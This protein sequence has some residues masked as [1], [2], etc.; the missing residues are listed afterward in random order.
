MHN[1]DSKTIQGVKITAVPAY[2]LVHKR[3]TGEF[4]HP[5]GEGNGYVLTF[6][7]TRIYIAGDT[8]NTPEMKALQDIDYAF[9]PMNLPYTMTPEMVAD[10]AKA[11]RPAVLYPYHYG[12]TD[13]NQLKELLKDEKDI[14][15][16]INGL[17]KADSEGYK[18]NVHEIEP[19]GGIVYE[20]KNVTVKA[21]PVKHGAWDFAFGF[22]FETRD[23]VV[24][25]SGDC[26]PGPALIEN[27]KGCDVLVHEVYSQAGFETRPQAWQR[28]HA[29][30]HTSSH[31]L[32]QIADRAGP[33]LLVLYHQ[34][35]WGASEQELLD[36][37][38]ERCDG[39]VVSGRDLDVL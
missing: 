34:L 38:Q 8:E 19:H 2:N 31:E 7:G 30:V 21:F 27:A 6:G 12:D 29:R 25:V 20:D 23:R 11:F 5:K 33:G 22:R 1:G 14:D 28:Y 32:A 16:R 35:F 17:E 3:D 39:P 9:L 26:V 18:V 13:T 10:A 15:V 24:L 4:F 36:E 37:I